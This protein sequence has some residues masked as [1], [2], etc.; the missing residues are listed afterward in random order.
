MSIVQISRISHRSGLYENLPQLS[1]AELGYSIDTRQLFIGNGLV[2][3][4]APS[5]GNTEILT[6]YSDILNLANTYSFKNSDAGYNPQTGN[7]RAQ[8]NGIAYNGTIYVVVGTGGHILTSI[9]GTTWSSTTSGTTNDLLDVVYGNGTFVAVGVN[10]TVLY[11]SNGTVWSASGAISYTNINAIVY[12]NSKFVLVTLQGG[13]YT[14]ANGVTWT[15]QTSGVTVALNAITYGNSKFVAGGTAGTII[16]STDAISWSNTTIGFDDVIGLRYITDTSTSTSAFIATKSGNKAFYSADGITWYRS[17]L[18]SFVSNTSDG[19]NTFAITSWGD[20]YKNTAGTLVYLASV[21]SGIEN[22]TY[23]YNNGSNTFVA[24]TGSG[25]IYTSSGGTSWTSR[26]SGVSTGLNAVYYDSVAKVFVIV[27]DSGVVLTAS[28]SGGSPQVVTWVSQTSGTTNNL[29]S[30]TRSQNGSSGTWIAVGSSGT[31]I[32]APS[33][34]P[35][36]WTTQ[37]SGVPSTELRDIVVANL[38]GGTYKAIAVG[39]GGIGISSTNGSTFTTWISAISN[40]ALDPNGNTVSLADLNSIIYQTFTPPGGS[41]T[42]YY[43]V[44][45]DHGV[46]AISTAGTTSS[47]LTKNL[48]TLA[49]FQSV[50]FDGTYFFVVGDT[51]LTYSSTQDSLTFTSLSGYYGANLLSPAINDIVTNGTINIM[52]GQYG[53]LYK[54]TGQFKYWKRTSNSLTYNTQA[55]TYSNSQFTAVGSYGQ[56]SY[57]SDAVTWT[58]Q[59]YSYGNST[60]VRSI[61]KKLDD[62]VSVKD[63]GAKGDGVTD[64]TEAI[65]RA[66]FELYCRSTSLAARKILYFPAG[67]YVVYG[68]INVPSYAR[69]MGEGSY[70]TQITQTLSPYIYPYVTW[71]MYT[72]DNLQQTQNLIGLN[73]ATLPTDIT[74]SN[75][76]LKSLNDGI[77]IDTASR[78]TLSNVRIKGPNTTT[79]TS[80]DAINGNVTAAVKL[81]GR[82]LIYNTDVNLVDC[83][84]DGFNTGIY[85]PTLQNTSN[86]LFDSCTF[87]NL[88]YGIYFVGT[89]A[90]GVTLS[91]SYMDQIY[92]NGV[93]ITNSTNFT[94]LANYFKD[95]G[96]HL[97]GTSNPQTSVI[98]WDNTATGC[99]TIG[100]TFERTDTTVT[101]ETVNTV[102][103]NYSTGLR[104]GTIQHNMGKSLSIAASTTAALGTGYDSFSS[105][106]AGLLVDYTISRNNGVRSGTFKFSLTSSGVYSIDDDSTQNSDVGVTFGFNGTDLTYTSDSN[107]TGLLN[108]AIRY[109]EML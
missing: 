105:Q 6:E 103:W 42:S 62:F 37:T 81:L 18:D 16:Y 1:K 48:G 74:I 67:N 43:I 82:S 27:G 94:S 38:G 109:L 24:L 102:E 63:F 84:F 54:S 77:V 70:N 13:V 85:L 17:L 52:A 22:F 98:Y 50:D 36:S 93:Y 35:N 3:D 14:S 76:T 91:N 7:A 2:T 23:I 99:A 106:V 58:N 41:S 25:G 69:I 29:K 92:Q 33:D 49:D 56:V 10:G 47:W 107:G 26:T 73:G 5:A 31:I 59:S 39:T 61:Q 88:Y 68:S 32:T 34:T 44:V 90:K 87:L 4:G 86:S 100:D 19:T 21:A 40:S 72:A 64:D 11:S 8:Y 66:L 30:I 15:S 51:G 60:T 101:V 57:S 28:P 20:V 46:F 108:Y 55:L 80:T 53:Y 78:V 71:V 89:S 95:V 83:L 75:L 45:G 12:G 104:L 65:N 97:T 79:T 96:D 9:D